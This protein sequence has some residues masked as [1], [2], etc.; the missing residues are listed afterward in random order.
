[1]TGPARR[2]AT[3]RPVVAIVRPGAEPAWTRA[4]P[5]ADGDTLLNDVAPASA[6][7][8]WAVGQSAG[9]PVLWHRAGRDWTPSRPPPAPAA[10][11]G[12]ALLGVDAA[13]PAAAI[14]VGG[15]YDRLAGTETP[16]ALHWDG[17]RWTAASGLPAGRV[18]TS[19]AMPAPDAAWAVG[20]AFDRRG[21]RAFVARW[22]GSGWSPVDLPGSV[23]GRLHAVAAA[24]GRLWAAGESA[25]RSRRRP[26]ILHWDGRGWTR[27]ALP[28]G[29]ADR[30]LTSLAALSATDVW[31]AGG[32]LLLHWDGTAWTAV[33]PPFPAVNTVA[34]GPTGQVWVA[35]G[36]GDLARFDGGR[37]APVPDPPRDVVW[38][39]SGSSADG[40]LMIV[41]ST[42]AG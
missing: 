29:A 34:A 18:L 6:D 40:P 35:G 42:R 37:W 9:G 33:D 8:A 41:G 23:A 22:D 10:A 26:L 5:P 24:G 25:G 16:V 12:A 27:P 32:G 28:T 17:A 15:H 14:A 7:L 19:V 36:R 13:S 30:P 3:T 11:V 4:D 38:L 20:H 21:P 39:G 1:M 2:T 31:A